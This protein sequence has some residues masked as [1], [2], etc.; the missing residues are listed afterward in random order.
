MAQGEVRLRDADVQLH[1][2]R[3]DHVKR[4]DVYEINVDFYAPEAVSS[5]LLW[6]SVASRMRVKIGLGAYVAV[7]NSRTT[8][9]DLGAFTAGETKQGVIE[10]VVPA[11]ADTRH[12]EL[13]LNIGY[14]Y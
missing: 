3:L 9:V 2:Y 12:E 7:G 4:D 10:V 5:M 8:A 14:G 11:G 6:T 1:N 13:S